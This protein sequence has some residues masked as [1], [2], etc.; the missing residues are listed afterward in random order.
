MSKQGERGDRGTEL[1]E[2]YRRS[3][4][5]R[6]AFCERAGIS[7]TTLDSYLRRDSER[8][9]KKQRLLPVVV[10]LEPEESKVPELTVVASNGRRV[11]ARRS[12]KEFLP[13]L[14]RLGSL[15]HWCI[16]FRGHSPLAVV[17]A[18]AAAGF[19]VAYVVWLYH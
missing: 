13:L 10:T 3:V 18:V 5:G 16:F 8:L 9:R 14:K 15:F 17:Q 2:P 7:V 6:R 1:V 12:A 4:L 11:E 19:F